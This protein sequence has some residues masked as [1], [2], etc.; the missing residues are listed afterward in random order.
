MRSS[1]S[2]DDGTR[3][4]DDPHDHLRMEIAAALQWDSVL[5]IPILVAGAG[6]PTPERLPEPLQPLALRHAVELSDPRW[7]S[8]WPTCRR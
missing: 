3:R 8:T 7:S 6:M 1:A 2:R 4:L 5:V